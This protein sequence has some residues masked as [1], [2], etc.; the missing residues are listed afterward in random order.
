MQENH[1]TTQQM[2]EMLD[3]NKD[4]QVDKQEFIDGV[5]I[6]K[7]PGLMTRD[8]L[9]IFEAIDTDHN[10][11]LSLNEFGLYLEGATKKREQRVRDLPVEIN[12][13][14]DREIRQLFT[15]FDEDNNG[16]IDQ[17]ELIKT[18]QGLGYEI[19]EEK[20][21]GMIRSVDKNGDGA[22]DIDE[23][24]ALMRPEMQNR[25]LEQDQRI[26]DFRAMFREADTDYSGYLSADELYTCLLKNGIDLSYEEL[27]E[28]LSEFD[29]DG[30]AQLDIDEWV[31][32]MNTSSDLH[33]NTE[34][35]KKT[36]LKIR[37]NKRLQVTDFM[38]ALKNLPSAFVPSVFH[39]KWVKES[40]NRPSDVLKAQ[41]DPATMTWKD[42]LPVTN[43][44][45]TQEMTQNR[46]MRPMIRPIETQ[47]GCEITLEGAQG[48]PLPNN[49][50]DF[51]RANIVKRAVRVGIFDSQ[52]KEY[53]ANAVQ[54]EAGWQANTE[55]KWIFSKN[56][57]SLN[58]VLFRSTRKDNLDLDHSQ[59]VFEF[60]IYYRS[61][62]SP[63]TELCCGWALTEDLAMVTRP[64]GNLKLQ[65][66]GGSPTAEILI[67]EKDVNTKRTG[68]QGF[69]KAFSSK[70]TSQLTVSFKPA[71]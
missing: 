37:M 22:I 38:K 34:G 67:Q 29:V 68:I 12:Q 13:E 23:F 24:S 39:Q 30:D 14:I 40:R 25:L 32:L 35:A 42:M 18:F 55:D 63:N 27:V 54:V 36:Y 16:Y 59:F 50:K 8:L 5:G 3:K 41:L 43:D 21:Q 53:F 33:F 17:N 71:A 1:F 20:A 6:L 48:I 15:I 51:D 69:L 4:G 70:I 11:Y 61:S 58:P 19:N 64:V 31:T 10:Q 65:V 28:L 56:N 49:G 46:D 44:H 26:E 2:H 60:V 57:V 47:H 52:K 7:I 66:H 9:M 62:G 45:L